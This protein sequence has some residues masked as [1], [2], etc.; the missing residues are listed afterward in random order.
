MI[1]NYDKYDDISHYRL[2]LM[3]EVEIVDEKRKPMKKVKGLENGL[4]LGEHMREHIYMYGGK[5]IHVKFHAKKSCMTEYIDWLGTNFRI[6]EE[7]DEYIVISV[8]CNENAAF[9]WALQYGSDLEVMEPVS[10]KK[11][12]YEMICNMKERYEE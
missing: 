7:D 12:V 8:K 1:G 5:S 11:R 6:S 10:L 2:D 3:T 4:N 9:L